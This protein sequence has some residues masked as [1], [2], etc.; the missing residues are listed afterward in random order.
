MMTTTTET[1]PAE[2]LEYERTYV[3]SNPTSARLYREALGVFPSGVTHD[4]RYLQPFPIYC[5]RAEGAYKWDLD[6]HR[7][8][9]YVGGHGALLLGH[10]HPPIVRAVQE[11]M[12][13]GTHFGASHQ[14]EI[15]WGQLVQR[16]IPSAER[17]KFTASGTEATHLAI[18]L[19]RA[20]SGKTGIVKF[21][22]HFHG[23][24]DYATAAVDP[25]Y[26]IPSSSGVPA[27]ALSTMRV[28]P[29]DLSAVEVALHS[30]EIAAVILEPT[31]AGWGTIP[32]DGTFLRGLRDLTAAKG[33]VLIFDEVITGFRCSPGGAQTAYGITP[34]M[35]T[36]AKILAG[37]LPGGAVAG[38]A[39][40]MSLLEFDGNRPGWNRGGRIA[41]PG[42][43]NANP[44][45]AA[46]GIACL[47]IVAEGEVHSH[48]NRLAEQLRAGLNEVARPY[49]LEGCAY[50]TFSMFHIVLNR[51]LL[52]APGGPR[53][54]KAKDAVGAKLRRAM[55]VQGVDLMGA[56]GMLSVAHTE[57]DVAHT[58]QAFSNA[59]AALRHEGQI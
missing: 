13:R 46:A 7:Y 59:L 19:A 20:F 1:V 28:L 22:G 21:E 55:L 12:P 16:L 17:V 27:E 33:V 44:L 2:V 5:D 35:T 39:D 50:G 18:R 25:P 43:F 14:L 6:G 54:A 34:D 23:W 42:T 24:H 26:D 48:V 38:R 41:H 49:D 53:Y 52:K 36:M 56:G 8:V 9:D 57:S 29:H 58:V 15:R 30:G 11:Q 45:S 51:D 31:G 47:E 10:S 32:V 37:G 40:I 3:E 4:N